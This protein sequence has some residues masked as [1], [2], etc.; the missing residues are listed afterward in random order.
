MHE[1]NRHSTCHIFTRLVP[2]CTSTSACPFLWFN[3]RPSCALCM[4]VVLARA[5]VSFR[6]IVVQRRGRRTY[7]GIVVL[8]FF[9]SLFLQCISLCFEVSVFLN[10]E[11]GG[12]GG[13]I[14]VVSFKNSSTSPSSSSASSWSDSTSKDPKSMVPNGTFCDVSGSSSS[15]H[16]THFPLGADFG[17]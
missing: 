8:R 13:I 4:R 6:G 14:P 2:Q 10:Q 3:R 9:L 12:G 15:Q 5:L 1:T 17:H 11:A 16:P 7:C